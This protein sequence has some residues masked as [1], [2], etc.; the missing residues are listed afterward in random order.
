[1]ENVEKKEKKENVETE[2]LEEKNIK[3]K[4]IE[5]ENI[6]SKL[7]KRKTSNILSDVSRKIRLFCFYWS[8]FRPSYFILLETKKNFHH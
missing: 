6:E 1:M 4:N 2:N 7:Q 8:L 5:K 3:I